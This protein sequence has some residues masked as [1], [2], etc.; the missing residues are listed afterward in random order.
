[1]LISEADLVA[2]KL[3]IQ[4]FRDFDDNKRGT[5]AMTTIVAPD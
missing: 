1:V 2:K 5:N 4:G 3:L